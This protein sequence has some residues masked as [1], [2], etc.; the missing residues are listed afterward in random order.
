MVD[1]KA[2]FNV[3][4]KDPD[5]FLGWAIELDPMTGIIKLDPEKYL[6]EIVAK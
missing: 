6:C 4:K 2:A 5:Y 1:F 3:L